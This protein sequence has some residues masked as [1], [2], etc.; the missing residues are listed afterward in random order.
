MSCPGWWRGEA[1]AALDLDDGKA[2][3]PRPDEF[4]VGR[5]AAGS[6]DRRVGEE[7]KGV[8]D[9]ALRPLADETVLKRVGVGERDAVEPTDA[10]GA[11][12]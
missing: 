9:K 6:D 2:R 7:E 10:D 11:A 8:A 4:G 3:T 5:G 1:A 12:E